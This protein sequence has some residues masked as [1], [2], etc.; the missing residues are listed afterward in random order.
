MEKDPSPHGST[1]GSG[2]AVAGLTK[3]ASRFKI[4]AAL[5]SHMLSK[6]SQGQRGK[7]KD[8]CLSCLPNGAMVA[9][10]Y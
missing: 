5:H 8:R 7:L 4:R 6:A 1:G 3:V 2:G 10:G 9:G